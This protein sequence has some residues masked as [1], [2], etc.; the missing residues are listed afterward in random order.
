MI[1]T[2][3][4]PELPLRYLRY[5]RMSGEEQNPRSPDQQFDDIDRTKRKQERDHWVHVQTFRDDAISGRYKRKRPGFRAMLDGIRSGILKVDL[6]LVDTLERFARLE[7]LPA[8][9]DELRKKY[10]VLILTSDTGFAD[11][12]SAVGK[13]YGAIEAVRASSA[14]AQK[15]HDVL[16]GKIDAVMRK[17]WPGGPTPCGYRL[18]ARTESNTRRNGRAVENVYH[19][20]EIDPATV[21]IPRK[22][23]Q[24]AYENGWGRRRIAGALNADADFVRKHGKVSE[25]L[26]GS[27]ITSTT[28]KGRYRYNFKATDI[29]DDCHISQKKDPEDVIYVDDFCPAIIDLAILDKVHADCRR[30]SEWAVQVRGTDRRADEKQIRPIAPGLILV[31]PLRG[32]VRCGRCRAAMAPSASGSKSKRGKRYHYFGC[33]RAGDG[34]CPNNRRI[35]GD[36][37]WDVVIAR[38][39]EVLFPLP[40]SPDDQCPDWLA[41]LI[42]ETQSHLTLRL[43]QDQQRQPMLELEARAIDDQVIGWTETLSKRDLSSLLRTQVEQH[44]TLAL[45]RKQEIA[46]ELDSL[47]SRK[48][49]VADILDPKKALDRLQQLARLLAEGNPSDVNVELSRHIVSILA[50]PDGSVVMKTNRLGVFEGAS[51]ILSGDGVGFDVQ[52]PADS[53]PDEIQIRP[54]ALSRRRTTGSPEGGALVRCNGS[55]EAPIHLPAKWVDAAIFQMPAST[56]WVDQHAEEVFLRRQAARLSYARLAAEFGV[57]PPTCRAAVM[58][59]LTTHPGAKDEV[60]LRAGGKRPPKFDVSQF[61]REARALWEA[62]WSKLKLA[63]KFACSTPTIDKALAWA[64]QQDGLPVPTRQEIKGAKVA[65]ARAALECGKPLDEIAKMLKNSDVT[66]RK[67]LRESFDSEG[68]PMPDLRSRRRKP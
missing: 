8:L 52:C 16:R 41:E 33:P 39:R 42:A 7:E 28:Y 1:T 56:S 31:Y 14:A 3:Y 22:A 47:S 58:R 15:A 6:I 65:A 44:V 55:I 67:Y 49:R 45:Q 30:R 34:R 62:D 64:Y 13:V 48:A 27:I 37:L 9:R 66:A 61:G 5:G 29:E 57:T 26:V 24:L 18:A 50:Y 63:S 23:Y 10:G 4:H 32:L 2:A 59:Y 60:R 43:D 12:T 68:K 20:L 17:H 54:R 19:V 36:W 51:E 46:C 21:E 35:R 38:L 11:P 25:S 53:E 40:R